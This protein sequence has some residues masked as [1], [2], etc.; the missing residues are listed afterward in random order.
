MKT[1]LD[2][3][4][5]AVF[6]LPELYDSD[7]GNSNPSSAMEF[8]YHPECLGNSIIEQLSKQCISQK[9]MRKFKRK[10][11]E[12][13]QGYYFLE[14]YLDDCANK[15]RMHCESCLQ[16]VVEDAKL[17]NDVKYSTNLSIALEYVAFTIIG[18]RVL[19]LVR[20][21]FEVQDEEICR[22]VRKYTE[23]FS[24]WK[25]LKLDLRVRKELIDLDLR[26]SEQVMVLV[27]G[28]LVVF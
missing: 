15:I 6:P 5:N 3:L 14:D 4:V 28:S 17:L 2:F 18:K 26:E 20:S 19:D 11:F 13:L 8:D 1:C 21:R 23:K 10:I 12:M 16:D 27:G 22:N 9:G 25:D 24:N 7:T